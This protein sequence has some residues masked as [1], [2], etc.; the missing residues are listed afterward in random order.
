[1]RNETD[2]KEDSAAPVDGGVP[3]KVIEVR[4]LPGHRVAVRFADGSRGEVDVSKIIF[5]PTPEVF[6]RLRDPT[7]FGEVGIDHGA[8]VWPGELD[9][10]PDAMYDEIKASGVFT[11]E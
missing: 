7:R 8:V 6:E 2:T 10:A 3:W 9:L 1:M 5:G 4:P 11:P